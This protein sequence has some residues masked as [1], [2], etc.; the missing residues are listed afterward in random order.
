MDDTHSPSSDAWD[1]EIA[2]YHPLSRAAV[3]GLIW[4]VFTALALIDPFLWIFPAVGI[5]V[6]SLALW[7]IARKAPELLGRNMAL[8]GLML[9]I[10]FGTAAVSQWASYRQM[11]DREARR[12]TDAWFDLLGRGEVIQAH[13]L[14]V[15]PKLRRPIDER[16]T[17]F[18][19]EDARWKE[20]LDA[21]R[22]TPLVQCLTANSRQAQV[23]YVRTEGFGREHGDDVV[24]LGYDVTYQDAGEKKSFVVSV[25][26]RRARFAD[27]R[28]SW[29]LDHQTRGTL[30][31]EW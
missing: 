5:L 17:R 19:A 21:F 26:A 3:F 8:I 9:S 29:M 12:F 13:Q 6:N 7:Q 23:R 18:Y 30:P 31:E 1:A 2:T 22:E 27:G 25:L 24:N 28:A 16:L 14:T 15:H 4:G 10:F 11:L 20:S